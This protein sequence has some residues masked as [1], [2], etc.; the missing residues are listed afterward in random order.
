MES[1]DWVIAIVWYWAFLLTCSNSY[2]LTAQLLINIILESCFIF[3]MVCYHYFEKHC[4]K[5]N[6]FITFIWSLSHYSLLPHR[7]CSWWLICDNV[8]I[9]P[10][11]QS[12]LNTLLDNFS[13]KVHM[14]NPYSGDLGFP[15]NNWVVIQE[16]LP[17]LSKVLFSLRSE[18]WQLPPMQIPPIIY[19]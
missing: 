9:L 12:V 16:V 17:K 6:V 13:V 15:C 11:N 2:Y 7:K 8:R 19:S 4:F 18:K 5:Y 3:L 1:Q 14:I 10:T